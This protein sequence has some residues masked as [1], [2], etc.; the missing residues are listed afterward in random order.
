MWA[1]LLAGLAKH[2]LV[3]PHCQDSAWFAGF[4][5]AAVGV[6][7]VSKGKP[8]WEVD[9][10]LCPCSLERKYAVRLADPRTVACMPV[11]ESY[12]STLFTSKL[13]YPE[14]PSSQLRPGWAAGLLPAISQG[15]RVSGHA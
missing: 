14:A 12:S 15:A 1:Y 13:A 6:K 8:H 3:G 5:K 4:G 9:R 11:T 10:D 2:Y 7:E